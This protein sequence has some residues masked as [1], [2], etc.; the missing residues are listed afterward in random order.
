MFVVHNSNV[1]LLDYPTIILSN[2][3]LDI[4]HVACFNT[5]HQHNLGLVKEAAAQWRA[6]S[7][8]EQGEYTSRAAALRESAR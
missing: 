1:C 3:Q 8:Q 4:F 7:R 5:F 6:L 2:S